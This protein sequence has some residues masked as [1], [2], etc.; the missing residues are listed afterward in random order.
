MK[1]INDYIERIAK[2][3]DKEAEIGKLIK[4]KYY[5]KRSRKKAEYMRITSAIADYEFSAYAE[6]RNT[7]LE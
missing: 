4:L 7:K 2:A 1:T 6:K 3:E 5:Y